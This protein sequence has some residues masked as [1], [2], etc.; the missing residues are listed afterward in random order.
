MKTAQ[1]DRPAQAAQETAGE[2]AMKAIVHGEY[3]EADEVL[4]L[5]QDRTLAPDRGTSRYAE[6]HSSRDPRCSA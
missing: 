2:E 5:E 6:R 4:R 3:G 1:H